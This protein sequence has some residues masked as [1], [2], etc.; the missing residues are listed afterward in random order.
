MSSLDKQ[1]AGIEHWRSLDE[2][3]DTP[4]F[5]AFVEREFPLLAD[6][7][8]A[9][10]TRRSFLKVMGASMALAGLTAC[11]WPT[12][13]IV[14]F[15]SRPEGHVP[16]VAERYATAMEILGVATGLLV[17]SYEGRPIKIEGNPM[18][19]GSLGATGAVAQAS[20]LDLYDPDRSRMVVRTEG[21]REIRAGWEDFT[22]F[23]RGHFG[24]LGARRGEGLRVLAE[25]SS[26]PTLEALRA[27]FLKTFPKAV[28]HEYEPFSRDAERQGAALAFGRAYRTQVSLERAKVIVC[29]DADLLH[30]HPAAVRLAREFAKGRRA[31]DGT[32]CRLWSV[33]SRHSL[34]GSVSDHRLAVPSGLVPVV[35]GR[36]AAELFLRRGMALPAGFEEILPA[37]RKCLDHPWV[38]AETET[39]VEDLLAHRAAS[40]LVAGPSQPAEVHALVH[41]VNAA[42]G[43][44]GVTVTCT[45]E[46]APERPTH[47]EA[48]RTLA[49]DI[50]AGQVDTLLVL[51]GNPAFD[52]PADL[53]FAERLAS[54]PTS[55]HLGLYRDE[56]ARACTWHLPRAHYLETWSDAR[57]WDGTVGV[58]QPLIE[59]LWGGRTPIELIG[60]V[61]GEQP[62]KGYDLVRTTFRGLLGD[63]DF[64][65]RWRQVLHDGL[66]EGSAW[67]PEVPALRPARWGAALAALAEAAPHSGDGMLELVF[68]PDAKLLDGRF[69]N[70]GW[71][72]ELPDPL[73]KLTWD[74]ALLLAPADAT[75][76]RISQEEV[77]RVSHE[78]HELEIPVYVMPGQAQGSATLSAGYGRRAGGRVAEGVGVNVYALRTSAAPFVGSCTVERTGRRARLATTQNHHAIDTV[79][80]REIAKR[81]P[82]LLREATLE[83]YREHPDFAK[84][85]G[86]HVPDAPLFQPHAYEGHRWGMAIDLS[87]CIGCGACVVAC[88]AENNIPVVGKEEVARGREMH[89]IRVD[90]YFSGEPEAPKVAHQPVTCQ[91]CEDAPCEQVCPVQATVHDSEGLNVM[92]YN[93]C[94]G[95]RY[96]SNNCPYKVRRFNWFN[97]HKG[98]SSVEKMLYN[99][100]VTVRGRGVMEKCTFCLQRINT[101]KIQAKNDRRPLR[102]GEIVPACAQVCPAQAITFGD[103]NDETSR[104]RKLH[105]HERSYAMLEELG[106]KPQLHYLA[107]LRNP[108]RG[109]G[110]DEGASGA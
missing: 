80:V 21:G 12:E 1:A 19:P 5:R 94:I 15:A 39:I 47:L 92:V 98:L 67:A 109:A 43:N 72:Q 49:A 38:P 105:D 22:E 66:L 83:E 106:V 88:Q 104:V 18:H 73:T 24:A 97:N 55:I 9:P 62:S 35:A 74:N 46:P 65:A 101:A 86:P 103:L 42:L 93:R 4:E 95:T 78:G 99:P 89:W 107:K 29:L 32:M 100:G 33:E 60:T 85:R 96:C 75:A 108:A 3:T 91:H 16:G 48:I 23:S 37:L 71:L 81:T 61:L 7:M 13:R 77:V 28:W 87:A 57:A 63:G 70:N 82:V 53:R 10:S 17:T 54:V 40:L 8:T 14:P 44:S 2:L 59:P 76:L 58:V 6:E 50:E 41:V 27:R 31:D 51:G 102:D 56:T 34:T 25:S 36:I 64:E 20:L 90:R 84:H 69:A 110:N 30:E 11:R 26:S 68:V 79:A 45:P 52:A